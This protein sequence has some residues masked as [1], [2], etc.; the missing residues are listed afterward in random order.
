MAR[1]DRNSVSILVSGAEVLDGRVVDTNSN[2]I[3]RELS[4]LGIKLHQVVTC[5]DDLGEMV[6]A[7]E[8]L[9]RDSRVILTSG[10]LGPTTD[11]L[12]REAVAEFLGVSLETNQVALNYLESWYASRNRTLDESNLKQALIPVGAKVIRNPSGTAPGFVAEH[13]DGTSLISLSGVPSELKGMFNESVKSLIQ[14]FFPSTPKIEV[15]MIKIFGVPESLV[16]KIVQSSDLPADLQVSYR[17]VFP[18]VHLALKGEDPEVLNA[19]I[20]KVT[21]K[22]GS[23]FIYT[24]KPTLSFEENI[25]ALLSSRGLTVSTAES[26]TGGIVAT[27]LTNPPGSSKYYL[28]GISSYS[29]QAKCRFLD[30][31]EDLLLKHGAVS[32]EVAAQMADG[33]R[34]HFGSDYAIS[35]TGVAG[36]DGGTDA[37]PVG[38]FFV[39]LSGASITFTQRF[40]YS[41][42]RELVRRYAAYVALD[43]LRRKILGIAP[44]EL[45]LKP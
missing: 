40:M 42:S 24:S 25:H 41:S 7:L 30:V 26:C 17:A 44:R 16:G 13:H 37:K 39:G 28:G 31:T 29:N 27:M 4:D 33:A 2:F 23:E 11:D 22:I 18:E 35:V 9:A 34:S 32:A 43:F 6:A 10:G 38:T 12:T 20:D 19:S 45:P 8:F 15:R 21:R 14:E 5:G 36:P 1:K 3:A